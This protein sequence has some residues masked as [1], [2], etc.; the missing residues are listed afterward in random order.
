[1]DDDKNI[2]VKVTISKPMLTVESI[3]PDEKSQDDSQPE[4]AEP[5]SEVN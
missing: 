4:K 3:E 1:M 2:V 5:K